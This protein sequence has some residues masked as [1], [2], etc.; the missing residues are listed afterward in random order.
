MR[1]TGVR[2]AGFRALGLRGFV[3]KLWTRT[4]EDDVAGLA[5]ELAYAAL[6][7]LFPFFIFL[8]ALLPYLPVGDI[9][10]EMMANIERVM[11]ANVSA[12][13]GEFVW[14][15]VRNPRGD[16][17]TA[18]V[19]LALFSASRGVFA[20]T[21]ALNRAYV[22]KE[23]RPYWK[24]AAICIGLTFGAAIVLPLAL[25][26]FVLGSSTA[27][28]LA[29][30]FGVEP[31]Y[32][33]LWRFVRWPLAGMLVMFFV[34]VA[35]YALPD[36]RQRYRFVTPGSVVST[37]VWV[38][39]SWGL[40][41]YMDSFGRFA[42]YARMYGSIAAVMVLLLWLFVTSFIFIIGGE[43]NAI[44]E[45]AAPTGKKPGE[46]EP[47]QGPTT[48]SPA[49]APPISSHLSPEVVIGGLSQR[50][51]RRRKRPLAERLITSAL[52]VAAL[53]RLFGRRSRA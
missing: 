52:A 26:F 43:M 3:H 46:R 2:W 45:H 31:Y 22:V 40:T 20:L 16:L 37:V 34:S 48:G 8:V 44:L 4:S 7:S 18:S 27:Y 14:A 29:A 50:V 33:T 5:S 51:A 13:I 17:L 9:V 25:A 10:E 24:T 6:F 19:L 1:L 39:A 49:L 21:K 41:V 32:A 11:P 36:V 38:A 35:Y 53:A 28:G 12:L 30:R 23:S 15:L 42:T 47:G